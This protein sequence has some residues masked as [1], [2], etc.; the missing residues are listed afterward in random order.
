V[1]IDRRH[2]ERAG[3]PWPRKKSSTTT[4]R[5]QSSRSHV[6]QRRREL[7]PVL[8]CRPHSEPAAALVQAAP[9]SAPR[10]VLEAEEAIA[11]HMRGEEGEAGAGK[12]G[13][14]GEVAVRQEV[15]HRIGET[16][17][18]QG[19]ARACRQNAAVLVTVFPSATCPVYPNYRPTYTPRPGVCLAASQDADDVGVRA[20]KHWHIAP[21]VFRF[22][23]QQCKGPMRRGRPGRSF[24]L[25]EG[26]K[27]WSVERAAT[28]TSDQ[29]WSVRC[30]KYFPRGEHLHF[31]R[32]DAQARKLAV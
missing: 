15:R 1:R 32:T 22:C 11:S 25:K 7:H 29:V 16:R 28:R 5:I 27:V 13:G 12:K 14:G 10:E 31:R 2:M 9:E 17:E 20:R 18:T 6:G 30:F 23:F 19:A 24:K 4:H 21:C 26:A 3:A 8:D